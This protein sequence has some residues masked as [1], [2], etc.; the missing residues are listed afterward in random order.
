MRLAYSS[1]L[2]LVQRRLYHPDAIDCVLAPGVLEMWHKTGFSP[3][4][5]ASRL[6]ERWRIKREQETSQV[7]SEA[8]L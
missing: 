1:W 8:L 4:R 3:A 5:V 7:E 2:H 6:N